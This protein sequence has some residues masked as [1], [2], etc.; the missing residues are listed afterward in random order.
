MSWRHYGHVAGGLILSNE[1]RAERRE[2]G[3]GF[4]GRFAASVDGKVGRRLR[5][6]R[7]EIRDLQGYRHVPLVCGVSPVP[8]SAALRAKRRWSASLAP[9]FAGWKAPDRKAD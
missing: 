7:A 5:T 9:R 2:R 8:A 3:R 1:T 4:P 6:E